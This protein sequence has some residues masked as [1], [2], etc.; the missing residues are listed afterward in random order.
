LVKTQIAQ[1]L[2]NAIQDAQTSGLL[3]PMAA[4]EI[5]VE[6][7]QNPAFGDYATSLPL[8]LARAAGMN[9]LAIGERLIQMIK[10]V[11]FISK[12]ELA[13]P[14]FINFTLSNEW[15]SAQVATIVD[16]GPDFG[17]VNIGHGQKIQV[18]F[19]SANPTGPLTVAF[20]RGG[21]LGDCLASIL[22]MA[23]YQSQREYYVNDAG[24]R[25]DA[26]YQSAMARYAEALGREV[27]F[28]ADG[29]HGAYMVDL[30][31]QLANDYGDRYLSSDG[32][33][34]AIGRIALEKMVSAARQDLDSM[35]I[36]YDVWFSEQSLFDNG[37]VDR[38]IGILEGKGYI[39]RREG[40][41][42]FSSTA[43]GEDK[44]NVLIRSTGVPTYFASDI[45]YHYNKF[46]AR[47][48][49]RVIDIWGAD[50]QGH[51][52]R[53]RAAIG[54]LGIDP[55]RLTILIHQMITLKRGNEI[56][57]MSKRTGDLIT[58]R[59]VLD[60]VGPDACR[61][62]FIAR[63]ADS[64]MDFD[65]ELA[66]QQSNENPVYYVQYAHARIASILEYAGEIN[67]NEA[68]LGLLREEA[69]LT[70]IRKMLGF[71]ELVELMATRL[72]PHHLPYYS[73]ELAALFHQFYNQCR[74]VTED[75]EL[76][77]ARLM[78]VRAAKTVLS[79]ALQ[80]MGIATP[81]KM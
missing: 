46:V 72:E 25:M 35:G 3:T 20:G 54:A 36:H 44:D 11:P 56:V 53:M 48:F 62:F 73:Q 63:S 34:E 28:P 51:V 7:P 58:L 68:N 26:F 40:A 5:S 80:L 43:L 15:V 14:G 2:R 6:Q 21:T 52:P 47:N 70:L 67:A 27:E 76:S 37:L 79:N 69:E 22:A 74:V 30:G 12:V 18:E 75:K 57:R 23:G 1:L 33:V 66:K 81:D 31:K 59:E 9:P 24:S 60:E 61:F 19:G 49:D 65:L 13:K 16:A 29:Y 32:S 41:T 8:R 78:L 71:P 17:R 42:W 50:H 64:Q 4:P 45:A 10:P 77:K 55:D 38:T 39:D